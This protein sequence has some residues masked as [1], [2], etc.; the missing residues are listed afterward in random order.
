MR[1]DE[2]TVSLGFNDE[3]KQFIYETQTNGYGSVN[4][5]P[6]TPESNETIIMYSNGEFSS[7]DRYVGG[8][9]Y[10]GIQTITYKGVV[11]WACV[12]NGR[13]LFK[14]DTPVVY[15]VLHAA[16]KNIRREFPLRGP[17]SYIPI[18]DY[19][20]EYTSDISYG[21]YNNG[22]C[23]EEIT[24]NGKRVYSAVFHFGPANTF[25]I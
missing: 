6:D 9:P 7:T 14:K 21:N 5:Q 11:C 17:A 19:G 23:H 2:V 3:L 24:I 18:N 4:A 16:L 22:K 15:S 8:E 10:F 12:Y 13:V 1:F 25:G 20:Y